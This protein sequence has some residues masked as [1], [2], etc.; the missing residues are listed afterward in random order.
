[1][2]W[3]P[4][5]KVFTPN[6][7]HVTAIAA[8]G[9]AVVGLQAIATAPIADHVGNVALKQAVF[10]GVG[11]VVMFAV[12]MPHY[13]L[14]GP[15]A[16]PL[17]AVTLVL[18]A[19][20]MLPHMP[21][22][23]IPMR[24][25]ARRWIDTGVLQFQP[26]ELAKIVFV[27]GLARYLRFRENYRGFGG[28]LIPLLIT[29]VPMGLILIEPDLGTAMIFLPVLFAMLLAAGAKL[30]HLILIIVIGVV[31]MPAMYPMLKPHQKDRIIALIS[32]L[33]DD[34]RH[35]QGVGFQ[36][37]KAITTAG[38]GEVRGYG[39]ERAKEILRYNALPEAHNDM[40]FAVV[41]ARWGLLGG[42][43]VL[44]LYLLLIASGLLVAAMN[45]DP[46][47][48]LVAVGVVTV[49][50]TQFV[51]SVGMTVGLLPITGIALPLISYGGSNLVMN[52]AMIGLILNVAS[53][54]PMMLSRP[55]FEYDTA[56]R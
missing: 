20:I 17:A 41:C 47:A 5:K 23:I 24:N 2:N 10:L 29:F 45:R 13:R 42:L 49:I 19:V 14:I 27:L 32:Q 18:L 16:Y 50:F 8:I 6:F 56:R 38:A 31:A 11:I 34:P 53:R 22:S 25:G 43:A 12:A 4:L 51:V 7:G 33:Q 37:Y 39:R 35:R 26:S 28:L 48:R 30:K 3:Q 21:R 9:L 44:A 40:I 15:L 46:F 52:F 55:A 36:A 54:R 1:V